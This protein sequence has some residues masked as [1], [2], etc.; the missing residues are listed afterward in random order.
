MANSPD[1]EAIELVDLRESD[2][3]GPAAA[4]SFDLTSPLVKDASD[5][6]TD[7]ATNFLSPTSTNR[8]PILSTSGLRHRNVTDSSKVR[9][10]QI[11]RF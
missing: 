6:S 11:L 3:L 2:A 4:D 1:S 9:T 5:G 10:A 8:E 7:S